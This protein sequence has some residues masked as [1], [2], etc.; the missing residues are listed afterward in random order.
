MNIRFLTEEDLQIRIQ[1]MN[2]PKVYKSRR[3]YTK[4]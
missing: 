1:W 4:A 2:D 3:I